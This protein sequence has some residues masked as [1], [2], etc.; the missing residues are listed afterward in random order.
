[1]VMKA[2]EEPTADIIR[3]RKEFAKFVDEYDRRRS[4]NFLQTFPEY[5]EFL[6]LC[7]SYQ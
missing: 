3:R 1:M 6:N 5:E 2:K 7:R 4:K